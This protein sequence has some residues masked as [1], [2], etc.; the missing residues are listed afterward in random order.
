[1][2]RGKVHQG[3]KVVQHMQINKHDASHKQ[4]PEQNHILISIDA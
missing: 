1:M 3:C 4:E 2:I